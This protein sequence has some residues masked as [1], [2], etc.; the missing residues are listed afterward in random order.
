MSIPGG[1]DSVTPRGGR[2]VS[3]HL[4]SKRKRGAPR[5]TS[6]GGTPISTER[7]PGVGRAEDTIADEVKT[8]ELD[9][10]DAPGCQGASHGD[11]GCGGQA[12]PWDLVADTVVNTCARVRP[13]EVIL[14]GGGVH[15]FPL[16]QALA[17]AIRRAGAFP[18][19][20]ITSQ[21][22]LYR[23]VA[24]TP[25]EHLAQVPKHRL[26]WL[27]DVDAVIAT[28]SLLDP[29]FAPALS[30]ERQ[31]ALA[32]GWD[33]WQAAL[34][35]GAVRSLY[36]PYP[37]PLL[38]G[39][40][41]LTCADLQQRVVA[42]LQADYEAMAAAGRDLMAFLEGTRA[43]SIGGPDGTDLRLAWQRAYFHL[44]DGILSE[45][46]LEAGFPLAELPAGMLVMGLEGLTVDGLWVV[47]RATWGNQTLEHVSF[48]FE[49]G[50][51]VA[52]D[53]Q[54]GGAL[55]KQILS[56]G[57]KGSLQVRRIVFGL[58]PHLPEP[59]GYPL[60]DQ[61]VARSVSLVLGDAREGEAGGLPAGWEWVLTLPQGELSEKGRG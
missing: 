20:N 58:N 48:R 3:S 41:G 7:G 24:E 27:E 52:A 26:R 23:T 28:D 31:A 10:G 32:A 60:L 39:R 51:L 46:R 53:A 29:D 9:A 30:R 33:P 17:L 50:R 56:G 37:T 15:A 12:P 2:D 36:V 47:P 5:G 22:L 16:I 21:E 34:A 49:G 35:Q 14:L 44:E 61:R 25:L 43:V 45:A 57:R 40:Y 42:S 59:V 6:L 38:A 18:E 13:G 54:A 4:E 11:C 1:N 19:M 8:V 55:L